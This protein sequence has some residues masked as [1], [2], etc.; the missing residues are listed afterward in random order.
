VFETNGERRLDAALDHPPLAVDQL[1]L[2]QPGEELHMVLTF[3]SAL[4][5]ELCVFP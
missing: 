5:G 2:H 3:G 1:Q 4:A